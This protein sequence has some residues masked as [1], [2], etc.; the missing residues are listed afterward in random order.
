MDF[1]ACDGVIPSIAAIS[2]TFIP[3]SY[4]HLPRWPHLKQ[5]KS[6]TPP[7]KIHVAGRIHNVNFTSVPLEGSG[8]DNQ[9]EIYEGNA[10]VIYVP[11][12]PMN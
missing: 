8:Q 10:D 9:V 1:P 12:E 7:P 4:T 11:I 6:G 5:P 3:V 2:F